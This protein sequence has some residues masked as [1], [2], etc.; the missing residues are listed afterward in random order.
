[1]KLKLK[2]RFRARNRLE[3]AGIILT[4]LVVLYTL[5]GF[6]ALPPL[7]KMVLTDRLA[8]SLHR[9][10][11]IGS[12]RTNPYVLSMTVRDLRVSQAHGPGTFASFDELYL[13]LQAMSLFRG[14][15]LKE[16]TLTGPRLTLI[17]TA[18]GRYNFSDLLAGPSG[19]GPERRFSINN[20]RVIRGQI[21]VDDRV[22]KQ[23]QAVTGITLGIPFISNMRANVD[24]WVKPRFTASVNG[25]PVSFAGQTKP[26]SPTRATDLNI[27]LH[28][29]D[30]HRYL[31]YAP[32]P[33]HFDLPSGL[34]DLDL[35]LAYE[36][37]R[38]GPKM[39]ISGNLALR[40]VRAVDDQGRPLLDLPGLKIGIASFSPPNRRLYLSGIKFQ[41]LTL[42]VRRNREGTINLQA[43]LGTSRQPPGQAAPAK[44]RE[45]PWEVHVNALNLPRATIHVAD[46][47]AEQPFTT[48]LT[49]ATLEVWG[50]SSLPGAKARFTFAAK[51]QGGAAIDAKGE[52]S[53]SPLA[54][55]GTV[56]LAGVKLPEFAPYYRSSLKFDV[57]DG[58]WGLKTGYRL[59]WGKEATEVLLT[60]LSS[61]LTSLRLREQGATRDFFQAASLQVEDGEL[62]SQARRLTA[63][64]CSSRSGRLEVVRLPD[65]RLNL[66]NLLPAA[67][68]AGKATAGG[69]AAG[70]PW[71]VRVA[72][73][74]LDD[75]TIQA[76]D[77][78]LPEPADLKLDRLMLR[79][80]N[81]TTAEKSPG[82]LSLSCRVNEKGA[83]A[84]HGRF[85]L[86]P[87]FADLA[88]TLRDLPVVAVQPYLQNRL[89][90][91]LT[92]GRFSARGSLL[93]GRTPEGAFALT[94]Q[95]NAAIDG[96]SS[97]NQGQELI[98]WK[99]LAANGID[100]AN[101]PG[102]LT[103]RDLLLDGSTALVRI[104]PEGRINILEA[105]KS[106]PAATRNQ[107]ADEKA[108]PGGTGPKLAAWPVRIDTVRLQGGEIELEDQHI[109]PGFD[110]SLDE[111]AGSIVG[112]SSEPGSEAA[113]NLQGKMNGVSPL[114]LTGK[115]TPLGPNFG[116]DMAL[117][118]QG[119]D[120][121]DLDPF[122]R[123]Y[124][125]Y[126]LEKGNLSLN[127]KYAI[128]RSKLDSRNEILFDQLTLGNRVESPE[129]ISLPVKLA[130][131]LL[132]NRQG[133][134]R[135]DIPVSGDLND[136]QFHLGSI[137]WSTFKGIIAKAITAPFSFLASLVG[138]TG[139]ELDHVDFA[140]GKSQLSP[141]ANAKLTK[142]A[143]ALYDRPGLKMDIKG[144]VA[145]DED[146]QALG[147]HRF[148]LLLR[149]QK[150]RD[151]V[152]AG[153]A[154]LS[155]EQVKI[156][157]E[158]YEK[159]L[160]AA[161]RAAL[162]ERTGGPVI[163]L[164]QVA[165]REQMEKYLRSTIKITQEDLRV[166]A[167]Q[168][169]VQVREH[170]LTEGKIE[171]N[172][173]FIVTP[174]SLSP[175]PK[176]GV[177]ASRADLEIK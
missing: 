23:I 11:A 150:Q 96:F 120:M 79:L 13:N 124:V 160:A 2:E 1:M 171:P 64:K 48:T 18:P 131:R 22:K 139:G 126:T 16:V 83:A 77:R 122:A 141:E 129:A 109:K 173:V 116:L 61:S 29:V 170:I 17:R 72:S 20:I 49:P 34:L 24:I 14:L 165:S 156:L 176:K 149:R 119:L 69:T 70:G 137:I 158:E 154:G 21:L 85:G 53:A 31:G 84:A 103:V 35:K 128:I 114:S 60:G 95:G 12:V 3:K 28:D 71:Q 19:K 136:P 58:T 117:Q 113:I 135:L 7:F 82:Q 68:K 51:E 45:E 4:A 43:L 81:F 123:K 8:S 101:H 169:A 57:E 5:V 161:Y 162:A 115:A 93:A 67:K 110:S 125:G 38:G 166:L 100:Y 108:G 66:A 59:A 144:Y 37:P 147:Q 148:Q 105:L 92:G 91:T 73:A 89:R 47:A 143:Q 107:P 118:L 132:Q 6:L 172:R 86:F 50:Y 75:F 97:L 55:A 15:I 157:P 99:S 174:E 76:Q 36:Q 26:F 9:K 63:G 62:D 127:L 25:S 10:V 133:E 87:Q 152:R 52:F 175:P 74:A 153:Q 78:T 155:L 140:Y 134:V 98:A 33:L 159:Y 65:G 130:L 164:L 102:H 177:P 106:T 88:V 40:N 80:G 42:Y 94:Y 138:W 46:Q 145:L 146:R 30:L 27:R 112:L 104:S 111:L 44:S 163:G 32:F 142:L 168:R 151:L 39:N 167:Q 56:E 41:P 90:P 121:A 54:A